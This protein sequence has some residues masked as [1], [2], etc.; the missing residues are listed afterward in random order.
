MSL[1][2]NVTLH[3]S[4]I[5]RELAKDVKQTAYTLDGLQKLS[6]GDYVKD[7]AE[8]VVEVADDPEGVADFLAK[9]SARIEWN[10]EAD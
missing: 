3:G 1:N 9:L 7:V 6:T 5:A 2:F 8:W 10:R 4:D